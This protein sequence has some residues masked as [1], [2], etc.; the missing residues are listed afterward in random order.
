MYVILYSFLSLV[1]TD[2]DVED[3]TYK[4]VFCMRTHARKRAR[5]LKYR[6]VGRQRVLAKKTLKCIFW[7]ICLNLLA[8]L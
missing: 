8:L 6:Y 5:V 7:K 3:Y 4:P 1:H 2:D